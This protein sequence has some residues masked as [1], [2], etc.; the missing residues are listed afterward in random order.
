LHPTTHS[1]LVLIVSAFWLAQE[2][3]TRA[4]F[5]AALGGT[6]LTALAGWAWWRIR[7]TSMSY[8]QNVERFGGL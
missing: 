5:S 3:A 1:G 7:G 8:L 4:A 6:V 2:F